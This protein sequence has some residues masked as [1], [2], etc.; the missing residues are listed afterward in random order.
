MSRAAQIHVT[1]ITK[2]KKIESTLIL[3][4]AIDKRL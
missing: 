1:F 3:K 2:T 4:L